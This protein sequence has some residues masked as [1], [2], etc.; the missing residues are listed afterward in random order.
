MSIQSRW[1]EGLHLVLSKIKSSTPI[2]APAISSLDAATAQLGASASIPGQAA[3]D[4]GWRTRQGLDQAAD[5]GA[6]SPL[7]LLTKGRL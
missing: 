7:G 5:R 2:A 3:V 4:A 6:Y 1:S